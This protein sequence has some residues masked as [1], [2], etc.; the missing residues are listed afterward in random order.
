VSDVGRAAAQDATAVVEGLMAEIDAEE[1]VGS[2]ALRA[3]V[4]RTLD[5]YADLLRRSFSA[6]ADTVGAVVGARGADGAV[7]T[8]RGAPGEPAVATVWAHNT[9]GAPAETGALRMT[10]L[11][12]PG[13]MSVDGSAASFAPRALSLDAGQ[14]ASAALTVAVPAGLAP[15]TYDGHVLAAGLPNVAVPVRLVVE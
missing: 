10:A 11:V 4:A 15:G 5:G 3:S 14:S 13:G 1:V 2:L 7:V 6:Y 9:D 12:G 8:L